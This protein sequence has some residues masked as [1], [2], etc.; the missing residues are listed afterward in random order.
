MTAY[1]LEY[2]IQRIVSKHV[3]VTVLKDS[4]PLFEI[5]TKATTSTERRLI[6]AISGVKEAYRIVDISK[7]GFIR[8]YH[9]P[10]DAFA[11]ISCCPAPEG[12]LRCGK[13]DHPAEQ[14]VDRVAP[15]KF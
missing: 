11:K 1:S 6:I 13:Q 12:V 9:N 4:L 10:A 3:P 5:I 14:L 8:T 2:D 15:E 7:I